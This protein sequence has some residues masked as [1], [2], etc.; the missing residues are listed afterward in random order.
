VSVDDRARGALAPLRGRGD[1]LDVVDDAIATL[2]EGTGSLLVIEGP[3][4]IGKSRLLAEV[5][6]RLAANSVDTVSGK[7]FEDQQAVPFALLFSALAD[8]N[9]S[10][11]DVSALKTLGVGAEGR[12]WVVRD[13]EAALAAAADQAPL[14]VVVDDAHW[15]DT[16]TLA[17]IRS[18]TDGLAAAPVAWI[19]AMRSGSIRPAVRDAVDDMI[20]THGRQARRLCLKAVSD[21]AAA[22]MAKDVLGADLDTGLTWMT[23]MAHGNPFLLLELLRGLREE[24]RISI[25]G[26]RAS[27]RGGELPRRLAESMERR[28]D[29]LPPGT[30]R[31]LQMASV[32]PENFSVNTLA[33]MVGH[34]PLSLVDSVGE[35]VRADLLAEVG[36]LLRFRHDLLRHATRDTIPVTLR[37]A[38]ERESA[39]VL[40]ESGSAP[41]E[42]AIQLARSADIGDQ[43]A[44]GTLRGAAQSVARWDPSSAADLSE[45]ALR[46]MRPDDPQRGVVVA[47]TIGLMNRALRFDTGRDLF[48]TAL[49]SALGAEEEG[50]IRLSMSAYSKQGPGHRAEQNRLA[51]RNPGMS[52]ALR[53]RHLSW[54]AYNASMEGESGVR[55]LAMEA[56]DAAASASDTM[57]TVLAKI[58]LANVDCA[59]GF[60]LRSLDS[61]AETERLTRVDDLGVVGNLV[62]FHRANFAIMAGRFGE[63]ADG[64]GDGLDAA[65]RADDATLIRSFSQLDALRA[66]A[67]G[68]LAEARTVSDSTHGAPESVDNGAAGLLRAT[69]L[70]QLAARLEDPD[71]SR[72]A[73]NAARYLQDRGPARRRAAHAALAMAAWRAGDLRHA[74]DLLAD[75]TA[76]LGTPPL[77]TQLDDLVL[78]ARVAAGADDDGLRGR[79]TVAVASLERE[80][81]GVAVFA[82]VAGHVRGL[83]GRDERRLAAA[84][85]VLATSGRPLLHA[86]AVEDLGGL[87]AADGD[88]STAVDHLNTAFDVFSGCESILDAR[89]VGRTLSSLGVHRRIGRRR[90]RTGWGSLTRQE[91]RVVELV[92]DGATNR[93]VADT[94]WLSQHTVNTHLRNVF[95]KLGV[96]SR[97]EIRRIEPADRPSGVAGDTPG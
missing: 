48:A 23:R 14:A 75:E 84:V 22:D 2:V 46:L 60:V 52:S 21:D 38:L 81:D 80:P 36:D 58:A 34:P 45:R 44:I 12:Y 10:L 69:V 7:A 57:A 24:D 79:V 17:A 49:S 53:V 9:Q 74:A 89:R 28:L 33:R 67:E 31:V 63:A 43:E 11:V 5:R 88:R 78:A 8:A 91:R 68:E 41:E 82:G 42:V 86:A 39:T 6:R 62:V 13:L 56:V 29:R 50:Q 73:C 72:V 61:L 16:G 15:A 94:L 4:G 19:I 66:V 40:L 35:A 25:D 71:V 51:L 76:L 20:R 1:E 87:L 65:R 18:L 90:Q 27:A 59:E 30:R 93:Q 92:A 70:S 85:D 37:K 3:P 64:I 54:L 47:E 83:L 95:A 26:G 96:R 97:E 32:L 55:S 77:A